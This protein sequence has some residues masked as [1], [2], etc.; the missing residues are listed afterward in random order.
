MIYQIC[1][2]KVV[3]AIFL[4]LFSWNE[5]VAAGQSRPKSAPA[6]RPRFCFLDKKVLRFYAYFEE[7]AGLDDRAPEKRIRHVQ[8][9]YHLEDDSISIL[10]PRV[11]V[12]KNYLLQIFKEK[13]RFSSSLSYTFEQMKII[14]I[15]QTYVLFLIFFVNDK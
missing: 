14:D 8:I 12:N 3:L 9:L 5:K 2:E 6:F 11:Q 13:K 7:H 1:L 10:E 4:I 15:V